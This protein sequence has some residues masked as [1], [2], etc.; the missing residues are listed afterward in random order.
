[1]FKLAS[2]S[3]QRK[4]AILKNVLIKTNGPEVLLYEITYCLE[5]AVPAKAYRD[6]GQEEGHLPLPPQKIGKKYFSGKN[7]VKFGH[8]V[9]FSCTYFRAKMSPPKVD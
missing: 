4:L 6:G 9:Y 7:H 3:R 5:Q 1:M 8:F 2:K